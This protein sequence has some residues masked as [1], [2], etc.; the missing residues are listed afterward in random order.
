VGYDIAGIGELVAV[1]WVRGVPRGAPAAVVAHELVKAMLSL[2]PVDRAQL[3]GWVS[4]ADQ[5]AHVYLSSL[6]I[7]LESRTLQTRDTVGQAD[8]DGTG[9]EASGYGLRENVR[10]GRGKIVGVRSDPSPIAITRGEIR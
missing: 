3:P 9:D 10:A 8:R 6:G 4:C 7:A 1:G 5:T 2:S